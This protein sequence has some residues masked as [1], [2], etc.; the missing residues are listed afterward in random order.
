MAVLISSMTLGSCCI[1]VYDEGVDTVFSDG[2]ICT[3]L[4]H[5]DE[6]YGDVCRRLGYPDDAAGRLRQCQDHE[7]AHTIVGVLAGRGYS[8]TLWAVAHG[9]EI[10]PIENG[11]EEAAT[12]ALQA[13]S[14]RVGVPVY[15]MAC[16]LMKPY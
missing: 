15:D 14:R 6:H 5:D 1:D 13:Y 8:P 9:E 7:I 3:A 10:D 11:L 16:L 2:V 12:L 4:P